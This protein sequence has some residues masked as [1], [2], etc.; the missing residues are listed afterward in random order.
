MVIAFAYA[1]NLLGQEYSGESQALNQQISALYKERKLDEAINLAKRVVEIEKKRNSESET[2]A[3]SLM[4]L[5][6][7]YRERF[8]QRIIATGAGPIMGVGTLM[9]GI[10]KDGQE[11]EGKYREALK[12]VEKVNQRDS[13]MA[14]S[15]K[16]GLAWVLHKNMAPRGEQTSRARLDEAEKFFLEALATHEKTSEINSDTVLRTAFYLG[17]FYWQWTDFEKAIPYLERYTSE[18]EKKYG[19]T[20]KALVP[21]FRL[22]A[23]IMSVT[24]R[25]KEALELANRVSEI[26][27]QPENPS[28]HQPRLFLRAVKLEKAKNDK[29]GLPDDFFPPIQLLFGPAAGRGLASMGN[30]TVT[31]AVVAIVVDEKGNVVEAKVIDKDAKHVKD[32]EEAARKSKF[33]PFVYKGQ[34]FKMRGALNYPYVK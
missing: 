24:L 25:E 13:R 22:L 3:H 16:S 34:A 2:H 31:S 10:A 23:N 8:E 5:A 29:V 27:G 33:R 18:V 12:V 1:A 7:L 30:A 21:G 4:N 14:G 19:R 28:N 32:I 17:E 9:D 26:T 6:G 15:I 20:G 11:A